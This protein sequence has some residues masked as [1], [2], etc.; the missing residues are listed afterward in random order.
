MVR[1]RKKEE[2]ND[3]GWKRDDYEIYL[4]EFPPTLKYLFKQV[5]STHA[6]YKNP[7]HQSKIKKREIV[8]LHYTCLCYSR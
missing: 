8:S 1:N 6:G 7:C 2:I 5:D 4:D 3:F